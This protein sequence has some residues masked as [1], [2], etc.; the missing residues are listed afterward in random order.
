MDGKYKI[1]AYVSTKRV[2]ASDLD[3]DLRAKEAKEQ[4]LETQ[5][6]LETLKILDGEESSKKKVLTLKQKSLRF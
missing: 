2:E 6:M 5:L 4:K 3:E 1:N